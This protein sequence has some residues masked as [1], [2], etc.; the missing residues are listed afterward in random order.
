MVPTSKNPFAAIRMKAI[1]SLALATLLST[2]ALAQYPATS[3]KTIDGESFNTAEIANDGKPVMISFWATW[4]KP[5]ISELNNIAE[6]YEDWQKETGVKIIAVSIDDARTA[7][8]VQSFVTTREWEYQALIDQNSDFKRAMNVTNVPHT[9]IYDGKGNLIYQH[10]NYK[11]G[12]EAE[13]LE[14]L[15]EL[16][17]HPQGE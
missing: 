14:K 16:A 17:A 1:L 9:F 5:C 12:D 7:N 3:I 13:Y 8:R 10:P 15:K 2:A 11:P 4:C 6:V